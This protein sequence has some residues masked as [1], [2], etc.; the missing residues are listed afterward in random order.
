MEEKKKKS[1]FC[2]S[3]YSLIGGSGEEVGYSSSRA[4]VEGFFSARN[5]AGIEIGLAMVKSGK[6]TE[7]Q[8][9]IRVASKMTLSVPRWIHGKAEVIGL[10]GLGFR[11]DSTGVEVNI[12][13]CKGKI[14]F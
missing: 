11:V 8:F 10:D 13:K 12:D 14:N 1:D 2:V 5:K 4:V 6:I 3:M 9:A 7:K